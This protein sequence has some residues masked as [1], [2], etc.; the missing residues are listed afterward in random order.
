MPY[1]PKGEWRCGLVRNF[2]T[3]PFDRANEQPHPH[4]GRDRLEGCVPRRPAGG[5]A[6]KLLERNSGSRGEGPQP[7]LLDS[8][9]H[10][11]DQANHEA[12]RTAASRGRVNRPAPI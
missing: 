3:A 4:H 5:D 10:R 12:E 1:G 7:F 6:S 2:R 9:A 11:P 8:L